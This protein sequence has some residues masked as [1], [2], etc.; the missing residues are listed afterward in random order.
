MA[1]LAEM[2]FGGVEVLVET[3]RVPG[4]ENTSTGTGGSSKM[5]DALDRARAVIGAAAASTANT[6]RELG[7][8]TRPD[9]LEVE[10]GVGFSAKGDI[11]VASGTA[12]M[13]LKVKL[14][15]EAHPGPPG[16]D[17]GTENTGAEGAPT[18]TP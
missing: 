9:R 10:F 8:K 16:E 3:V 14:I 6:V 7:E 15:Y 1:G 12:N 2:R 17:N 4:S 18:P 11:I 5:V 13:S